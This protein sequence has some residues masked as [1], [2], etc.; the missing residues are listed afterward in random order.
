MTWIFYWIVVKM[1]QFFLC[2]IC[3]PLEHLKSHFGQ[4]WWS[5]CAL[6]AVWVT[7]S[8]F[9][10]IWIVRRTVRALQV[11]S[12]L[13]WTRQTAFEFVRRTVWYCWGPFWVIFLI[14]FCLANR[15]RHFRLRLRHSGHFIYCF[16]QSGTP[17]ESFGHFAK[18]FV[19]LPIRLRHVGLR[20]SYPGHFGQ[21][22]KCPTH[23]LRYW[24]S[25]W[26]TLATTDN[27]R[28]PPEHIS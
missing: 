24:A 25:L 4:F 28:T 5:E 19:C 11:H 1:F 9:D 13:V 8:S 15:L 20:Q 3:E 18:P 22:L 23:R 17:S 14:I 16:G 26:V 12:E 6:G 27:I 21:H 2:S 10:N 7:L